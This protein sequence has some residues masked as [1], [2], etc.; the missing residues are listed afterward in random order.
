VWKQLLEEKAAGRAVL[1]ISAELDEIYELSDRIVTIYEGRITG[2]YKPDAP[3]E[4]IGMGMT[5]GLEQES[6]A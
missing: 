2:E 6:V 3:R 1:L 5:G 4:E